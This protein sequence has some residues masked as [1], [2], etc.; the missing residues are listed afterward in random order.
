MKK[1]IAT[2]TAML[3]L[4]FASTPALAAVKDSDLNAY[5]ERIGMESKQELEDYLDYSD[6]TLN[7]FNSVQELEK[8]LGAPVTDQKSLDALFAKYKTTKEKATN[9]LIEN[10]E[11]EK[12]EKIEDVYYFVNDLEA[13][14]SYYLDNELTPITESSLKQFLSDYGMTKNEL[15]DLLAEHDDSLKNYQYIED[16]EQAVAYYFQPSADVQKEMEDV[17]SQLGVTEREIQK[18]SDYMGSVIENDPTIPERLQALAEKMMKFEDFESI[19]Q[20][21]A[22]DLAELLSIYSEGMDIFQLH[23]KFYLVKDGKKEE[24]SIQTLVKLNELKGANLLVELYGKSGELLMD[25]LIT[26]EIAGS[27][28]I[29][30]TGK[31]L[32]NTAVHVIKN[33]KKK[34]SAVHPART[35]KGAKLPKTAGNYAEMMGAGFLLIASAFILFRRAKAKA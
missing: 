4:V 30:D 23:P 9:L 25:L 34:P 2:I 32:E 1:I 21:S 14:L 29:K 5:L 3:L 8:E 24:L 15:E 26:P 17:L 18:L 22:K 31:S 7:D 27:E 35:E 12:G 6:L 33:E 20:L 13:D 19:D 16:L 11:L 28:V 10:G